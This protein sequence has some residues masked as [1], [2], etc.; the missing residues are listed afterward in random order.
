[1]R[2]MA[3]NYYQW[4]TALLILLTLYFGGAY[5]LPFL[6]PWL[7]KFLYISLPFILA[8]FLA[9]LLDP[10]VN[11]LE[12]R[13]KLK[14]SL[15]VLLTLSGV[16]G[17]FIVIW[18]LILARLILETLRL[19]RELP[20]YREQIIIFVDHVW[21]KANALLEK[22]VAFY[23]ELPPQLHQAVKDNIDNIVAKGQQ[24]IISASETLLRSVQVLPASITGGFVVSIIAILAAFFLLK[25]KEKIIRFWLQLLNPPWGET[26][27]EVGSKIILAFTG[28]LK[29]QLI[30]ITI[31]TI[32]AIGGLYL[33]GSQFALTMGIVVGLMDFIPVLGPGSVLLP[34]AL[35]SYFHGQG[36]FALKLVI[37]YGVLSLVRQLLEAKV[38]A[39]NVGLHPLAT[40]IAIY[41]GYQLWGALGVVLGPILLIAIQAVIK[42]GITRI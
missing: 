12:A 22:G 32:L 26:T 41:T 36:F 33:T 35:L 24:L 11:K 15:A 34:W 38:V 30:L 16:V 6:M 42:T 20:E 4:L 13:F 21:Q 18:A 37:L 14:R 10:L 27:L 1:M 5:F 28:Y 17:G 39:D 25:D 7:G 40:L 23:R 9:V 19:T 29:A 8:A 2:R 31:T 3:S